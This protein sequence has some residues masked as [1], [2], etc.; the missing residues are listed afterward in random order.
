MVSY[1]VSEI[2]VMG[3][4]SGGLVRLACVSRSHPVGETV[5]K[6]IPILSCTDLGVKSQSYGDFSSGDLGINRNLSHMLGHLAATCGWDRV[7]TNMDSQPC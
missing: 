7:S 3:D 5:E 2:M 6:P 1:E 4:F